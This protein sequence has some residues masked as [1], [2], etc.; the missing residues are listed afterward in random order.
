MNKFIMRQAEEMKA[1]LAKI[2]EELANTT[3]E[4]SSGGGMVTVTVSG[5]HKIRS[6][7]I[8]PEVVDPQDVGMLE[9]LVLAAVNEAMAK[10][11]EEAKSRLSTLTGG[12]F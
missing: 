3:M 6:I 7:K 9:D 10:S 11:Q 2:Q 12:L 5:D 8:S 4:A 1:K